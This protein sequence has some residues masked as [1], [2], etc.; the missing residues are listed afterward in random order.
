MVHGSGAGP[1]EW[2]LWRQVFEE[3]GWPVQAPEL[4]PA[5][6]GLAATTLEDYLAQVV[7]AIGACGDGAVVIGASLGGALALAASQRAQPAALVLVNGVP[8]AGTPG[9][10]PQ[11]VRFLDVVG[12]GA[13]PIADTLARLPD[14]AP[15]VVAVAPERWRD[16][17]GAVMR[18]LWQGVSVQTPRVPTLVLAGEIDEDVPPA[19]QLAMARRL[20]ADALRLHG[21][22]HLGALL[23]RRARA[24]ARLSLAWLQAVLED[25]TRPGSRTDP[26]GLP[27]PLP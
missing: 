25:P 9:W 5:A 15:E 26:G 13:R 16:E 12:W 18:A 21:T 2:S 7:A 8:P 20:G 17:S 22:S 23:G 14:A 24:A 3:A 1:W 4:V 19:V 10:P 6:G 27:E 11:R